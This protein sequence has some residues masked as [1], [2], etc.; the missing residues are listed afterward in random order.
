MLRTILKWTA[1]GIGV[2][3]AAIALLIGAMWASLDVR[4]GVVYEL[5]EH[6]DLNPPIAADRLARQTTALKRVS[7]IDAN[8]RPFDWNA[9]PHAI[10]WINEWANWC[11][12]CLMEM[13][14]MKALQARIGED[15]LRIVLL[16]Q[17]KLFEA[18]K[19]K[20]KDLGLDFELVSPRDPRPADLA[21]INLS[22]S[23]NGFLLPESTFMRVNGEGLYA[24][25]SPRD[26]DSAM[27][28]T[29]VR[30]WYDAGVR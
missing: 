3:L 27:W 18:D 29:I 1:I 7:L 10:V 23:P 9:K 16:S 24:I 28:E 14:A 13:D 30:H 25:H 6:F 12:P 15:R 11:V 21:A 4:Y 17:P 26:W 8:G 22:R 5:A 2:P 20:A 19:K